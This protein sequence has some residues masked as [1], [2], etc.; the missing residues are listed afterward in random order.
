MSEELPAC[1]LYRTSVALEGKEQ[2]VPEGVLVMFHNH[3]NQ[4]PPLVLMPRDNK[5][6]RWVFHEKGYLVDTD[7]AEEFLDGL[8]PLPRQGYYVIARHLHVGDAGI[9]GERTLIQIGYNREGEPI[10]FPARFEGNGF[11]FPEKG[12]LFKDLGIF[13]HVEEAGFAAPEPEESRILH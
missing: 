4:G 11:R 1:G 10:V 2:W 13:E 8:V 7:N 5:D 6:N 9:L 3:S 12:Y